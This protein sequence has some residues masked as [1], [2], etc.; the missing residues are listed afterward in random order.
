MGNVHR[1]AE[2]Q[3]RLKRLGVHTQGFMSV[4]VLHPTFPFV[5][6]ITFVKTTHHA[7]CAAGMWN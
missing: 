1:G 7:L 6:L 2:S 5:N 3:T 4:G